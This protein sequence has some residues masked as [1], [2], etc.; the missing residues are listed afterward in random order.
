[1]AA[2]LSSRERL[3]A[4]ASAVARRLVTLPCSECG[5]GDQ[6]VVIICS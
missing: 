1:M 4:A 3:S 6:K 2:A 5:E